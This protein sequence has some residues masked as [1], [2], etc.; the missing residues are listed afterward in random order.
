M[1]WLRILSLVRMDFLI[2][3]VIHG[4]KLDLSCF[5][6]SFL[7]GAYLSRRLESLSEKLSKERSGLFFF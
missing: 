4:F 2:P 6:V 1:N 5:L 7:V 3:D